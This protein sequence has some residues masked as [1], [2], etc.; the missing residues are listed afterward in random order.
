MEL[1]QIVNRLKRK[2]VLKV[3]DE[4]D[5]EVTLGSGLNHIV[6]GGFRGTLMKTFS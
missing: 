6:H 1:D 3:L 2:P 4:N 5:D